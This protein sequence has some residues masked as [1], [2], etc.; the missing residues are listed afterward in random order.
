MELEYVAKV[1]TKPAR[2]LMHDS[3]VQL[4]SELKKNEIT[5]SVNMVGSVK[6]NLVLRP[7]YKQSV[8]KRLFDVDYNVLI[9]KTGNMTAADV[10]TYFK[11]QL[12]KIMEQKNFTLQNSS[13]KAL[14]FYSTDKSTGKW[15]YEM[16]IFV[17]NKNDFKLVDLN[18]EVLITEKQYTSSVVNERYI[19]K[20]GLASALR[21]EY[22]RL[23]QKH[24]GD[25]R[26]SFEIYLEAINCV[27]T[28]EAKIKAEIKAK[29][30]AKAK[31]KAK[32]KAK[33]KAKV[34]AEAKAKAR[35]KQKQNQMPI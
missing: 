20:E 10:S 16:A 24:F 22:K 14:K 17:K 33:A 30:K 1:K 4:R 3:F 32:I 12:T 28:N 18:G 26:E 9:H 15:S 31:E 35:A 29:I 25:D 6:R 23:K 7:I 2:R 8:P 11:K 27:I 34:K 21:I 19:N 13:K 5:F